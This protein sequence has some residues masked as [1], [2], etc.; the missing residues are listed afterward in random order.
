MASWSCS[1]LESKASDNFW[2]LA[3]EVLQTGGPKVL[4][5]TVLTPGSSQMASCYLHVFKLLGPATQRTL[6]EPHLSRWQADGI[7]LPLMV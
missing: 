7:W 4:T 3:T 6:E 1:A 5:H 2:D